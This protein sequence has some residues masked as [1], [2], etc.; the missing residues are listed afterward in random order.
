MKDELMKKAREKYNEKDCQSI[1]R[2]YEFAEK[3]HSS[4]KACV[5]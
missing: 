3:A 1:E 5:G 4:Q 2:A